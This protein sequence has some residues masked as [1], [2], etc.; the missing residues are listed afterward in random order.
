[1]K[2]GIFIFIFAANSWAVEG[3]DVGNGGWVARCKVGARK[4]Y[5]LLD[6][7]EI[8]DSLGNLDLTPDTGAE[9]LDFKSKVSVVLDR[10]ALKNKMR[11]ELYRSWLNSWD[12]DSSIIEKI[13]FIGGNDIGAGTIPDNCEDPVRVIEQ[14]QPVFSNE[15]RFKIKKELWALLSEETKAGLLLHEFWLRSSVDETAQKTSRFARYMNRYVSSKGF[16]SQTQQDY[17][18]TLKSAQFIRAESHDGIEIDIAREIEFHPNGRVKKAFQPMNPVQMEWTF[19]STKIKDS[20]IHSTGVYEWY[21]SGA[22]KFFG[23]G[24][25]VWTSVASGDLHCSGQSYMIP[26]GVEFYEDG[27]LNAISGYRIR[28]LGS[29]NPDIFSADRR[30]AFYPSGVIQ[31][32]QGDSLRLNHPVFDGVSYG[33]SVARYYESGNLKEVPGQLSINV[34]GKKINGQN[35]SLHDGGGIKYMEWYYPYS[36]QFNTINGLKTFTLNSNEM[37][38]L[39]FNFEGLVERF[40]GQ[41]P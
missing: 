7:V 20:D 4:V 17:L 35:I 13:K 3:K 8:N 15:K 18:L 32:L 1:M 28:C 38:P 19:G 26:F 24:T 37:A 16:A 10:L 23:S 21:P 33:M 34:Q 31:E 2:L 40:R 11:A 5:Q 36:M 6:F 12:G 22:L 14:V 9:T 29:S 25:E 30:I 41:A 39:E 27:K